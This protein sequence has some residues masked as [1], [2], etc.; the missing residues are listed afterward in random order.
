MNSKLGNRDS[1][2]MNSTL[3]DINEFNFIFLGV[4]MALWLYRRMSLFKGC[5]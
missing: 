2:N 5:A 1:L 4:I 3:D